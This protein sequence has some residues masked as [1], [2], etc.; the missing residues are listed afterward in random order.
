MHRIHKPEVN[1]RYTAYIRNNLTGK[2]I[3]FICM[4]QGITE[5]V[6]ASFTQQDIVGASRPRIVYSSTSAKTMSLTLQNLTE[7]YLP[8]GYDALIQYVRAFQALVYPEYNGNITKSPNLT[9]HIG[10]RSMSCVCTSVN[11]TW[12]NLVRDNQILSCSIDL[13]M[14]MTRPGVP[15][16]T[17]IQT[18]G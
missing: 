3:P 14:L 4:P 8:Q 18:S 17:E 6:S 2:T 16:A 15:G 13:Q 12:G 11:V 1:E 10:D 5:S 9:L 7:D